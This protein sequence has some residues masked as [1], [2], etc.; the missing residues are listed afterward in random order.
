MKLNLTE[1]ESR[2][3]RIRALPQQKVIKNLFLLLLSFAGY[4]LLTNISAL[5]IALLAV[6]FTRASGHELDMHSKAGFIFQLYLTAVTV[7]I[8]F[9]IC[10]SGEKRTARTLGITKKHCIPDYLIG[11]ISGFA[12]F[13]AVMGLALLFGGVTFEGV[14][15]NFSAVTAAVVI[16]GWLI[17]GFSEE[18]TFRGYFLMSLG[19]NR[20]PWPAVMISSVLFGLFHLGNPG[21]TVL[22]VVNIV[23]FGM[24]AALLFLRT[25]S[26]WSCA[27][28]HAVW[29]WAQGN[30]YG[31]K[32]SGLD[33]ADSVLRFTMTDNKAWVNG[34]AFG[35]EGG[36]AATA[37]MVV[38][39]IVIALL[40][41]RNDTE[42]VTNERSRP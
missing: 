35:M 36:L 42:Q 39:I 34:G 12:M 3:A 1:T 24:L 2:F 23:L 30:F 21:V 5:V 14:S 40:P 19:T 22:A 26:I 11:A 27:A 15:G 9:A 31:L 17:Q 13:S 33:T 10:L 6:T 20:K 37:V 7:L 4:Y 16:I 38:T 8:T 41:A 29:N 32:V 18:L 25:D 28:M